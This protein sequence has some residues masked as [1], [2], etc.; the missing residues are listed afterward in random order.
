MCVLLIFFTGRKV[1][2]YGDIIAERTGL[3][4]AWVGLVLIALVT[5]LPEVFTGVSAITLVKSPDLTIGDLFGANTF[6]LLNLA[7]LDIAH[8]NGSLLVAVS[9]IHKLTARFSIALV[10]TAA[11]AILLS[12]YL[13]IPAIGWIGWST[14]VIVGLYFYTIRY[15]FIRERR[16][17]PRI[18]CRQEGPA[19]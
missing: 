2:T 10:L 17:E 8:R 15:I 13:T 19:S 16:E 5:S 4:G 11:A 12:N 9:S 6:N 18:Y 3:G 7:L 14:P 1:A